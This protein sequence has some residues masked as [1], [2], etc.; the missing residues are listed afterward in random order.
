MKSETY[1]IR[2]LSGGGHVTV[3]A[4]TD[5]AAAASCAEYLAMA[6]RAGAWGA[7]TF[8]VILI[9]A[10]G[11]TT[12]AAME[13]GLEDWEAAERLCRDARGRHGAPI[14]ARVC[15]VGTGRL[16]EWTEEDL[17]TGGGG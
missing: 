15:E 4:A 6:E 12:L 10:E 7:P 14:A 13:V 3:T 11:H 9:D 8:E 2:H 16:V 1:A 5:A 17:A